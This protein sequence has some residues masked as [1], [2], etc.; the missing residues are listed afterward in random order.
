MKR[1]TSRKPLAIVGLLPLLGAPSGC[2]GQIGAAAGGSDVAP[3]TGASPAGAASIPRGDTPTGPG[4]VVP[5]STA[6]PIVPQT[7]GA[8]GPPAAAP[9]PARL[10]RLAKLEL[11]Q[12]LV[13][14]FGRLP[15][16]LEIEADA[17]TLGYSTGE[18]RSAGG[19][20]AESLRRTAEI[21]A[22]DFR[23]TVAPPA[24]A[25]GCFANDDGGRA[26]A[27]TFVRDLGRRAY[28][29]PL[30]DAEA[31]ALLAVYD[32]GRDTG[33]EA[34]PADRFR[35]G[36]EWVVRTALRSP[37][38][39]YRAELGAPGAAPGAPTRLAP[40]ELAQAISYTLLAAPPDDALAAAAE[41]GRLA[42]ADGIA[43][44]ARRLLV[45]HPGRWK[46]QARR[47]VS[48]WL[49]IDFERPE[50]QKSA[51]AHPGFSAATKEALRREAELFVDDWIGGGAT[52]TKLL[53]TNEAF[54]SAATASIWG[55]TAPPAEPR[56]VALDPARRAGV[57]THPGFLGT[58]AHAGESS[59]I[60]RGVAILKSLLCITP[61]SLPAEVPPLPPVAKAETRTTRQ[62]VAAHIEGG[63]PACAGCH[64]IFNPLGYPFES[65]D[66]VG[67][68]R[69]HENGAPIEASGALVG[70]AKDDRP[71]GG[72]V[73]LVQALAGSADVHACVARQAFRYGFGREERGA[74]DA[75]TA[76]R[77]ARAFEGAGLDVRALFVA[78]VTSDAFALRTAA[79]AN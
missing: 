35:A 1:P 37:H 77:A 53:T 21:V 17:R 49:G 9:P 25:A 43:A 27:A 46:A 67:A 69:T 26:C 78:L 57:L 38:F 65:Y 47:F 24:F 54:V 16:G 71:V 7:A 44:E 56:K 68:F 50:W 19:S 76:L 20:Y 10:V 75:C 61:P 52:L 3:P 2:S 70:T 48:E 30:T 39:V 29:R 18:G 6:R 79:E 34:D 74:G 12:T 23:K 32:A 4:G 33:I 5:G 14:L 31:T 40:H 8:C 63:G 11:E 72:A 51:G 15:E 42:T 41:A 22:A 66:A 28:R 13:A 73:E 62:R 59:P 45:A 58:H 36:L 55:V 60:L 64:A